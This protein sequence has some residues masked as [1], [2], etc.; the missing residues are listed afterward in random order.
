MKI[1]V[2]LV[3]A[4]P[5]QP[6]ARF[7][8]A[9]IDGLAQSMASPLVGLIQPIVVEQGVGEQLGKYILVDG[10]RRVRAA[11]QLGWEMIEAVIRPA[12]NHNGMQRLAQAFVANEQRAA[13]N[14][15][16]RARAYQTLLSELGSVKNV[17]AC[18]G[19]SDATIYSHLAL[20]EFEPEV[21]ALFER[22]AIVPSPRVVAALKRLS[23]EQRVLTATRAAVRGV[24]EA[25]L[26]GMLGR[27]AQQKVV[28][29][30]PKWR[31]PTKAPEAPLKPGEHFTALSLIGAR[32]I[33]EQ[34]VA[35]ILATCKACELYDMAG[36]TTCRQCP[37]VDFLRRV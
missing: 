2:G 16:E 26:L 11:R 34:I 32:A 30:M 23:A 19:K 9:E 29:D 31:P 28:R 27:A 14:A 20:L 4:N 8:Q 25:V 3:L 1:Q 18:V 12:S 7:D 22:S 10:E 35:P 17:V 36:A 21:Q 6:R 15:M 37:L 5:N 33:P 13:M 24:S